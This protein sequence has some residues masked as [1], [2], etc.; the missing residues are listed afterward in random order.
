MQ[1]QN[2]RDVNWY[3]KDKAKGDE[4]RQAELKKIKEAEEDALS[5]ALFVHSLEPWDHVTERLL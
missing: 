4:E 2:N 3:N 1:W 5:L